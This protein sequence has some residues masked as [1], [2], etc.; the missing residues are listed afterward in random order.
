MADANTKRQEAEMSA[1]RKLVQ[2]ALAA[3]L[4][5]SVHDGEEV[6]IRRSRDEAAIVGAMRTTDDDRLF[7]FT[8][9][10][11]R[12]GLVWLVYGNDPY[13]VIAEYSASLDEMLRPVFDFCDEKE[14]ALATLLG[15]PPSAELS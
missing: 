6:T 9:D 15:I 7:F 12:K 5:V 4:H 11:T 8:S 1:I 3:G 14:I 13:D 10:G 2:T